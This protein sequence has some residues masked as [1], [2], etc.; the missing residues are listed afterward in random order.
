M[1]KASSFL[2]VTA[3]NAW[4]V[5]TGGV[6]LTCLLVDDSP[7]TADLQIITVA[8]LMGRHELDAA[9]TDPRILAIDK[10]C[11][12]LTGGL[13]TREWTAWVVQ[14]VFNSAE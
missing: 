6:P 9:V 10:R 14:P 4:I 3:T 2:T 11:H 8:A 1:A 7:V 13:L 5:T 12:P